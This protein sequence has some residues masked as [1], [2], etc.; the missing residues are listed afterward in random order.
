VTGRSAGWLAAAK[1]CA[2]NSLTINST[3]VGCSRL[4]AAACGAAGWLAACRAATV[5][6]EE[7]RYL[8]D[9]SGKQLVSNNLAWY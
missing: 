6:W 4:A 8:I 5:T 7:C 3:G 1:A 2:I 9:L